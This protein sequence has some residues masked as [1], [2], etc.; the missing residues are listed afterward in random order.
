MGDRE[1]RASLETREIPEIGKTLHVEGLGNTGGANT[2]GINE[3]EIG[4][5]EDPGDWK[6]HETGRFG[7]QGDSGYLGDLGVWKIRESEEIGR[8]GEIVVCG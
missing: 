6:I 4:K 2:W 8:S 3:L 5:S 7:I 1:T